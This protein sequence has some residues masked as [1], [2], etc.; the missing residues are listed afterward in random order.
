ML[1]PRCYADAYRYI[2]AATLR[3]Y[4]VS[5]FLSTCCAAGATLCRQPLSALDYAATPFRRHRR[6]RFLSSLFAAFRFRDFQ[7]SAMLYAAA[8]HFR[9]AVLLHC[10]Y[11]AADFAISLR[12]VLLIALPMLM[13]VTPATYMLLLLIFIF[14]RCF[15]PP[16]LSPYAKMLVIAYHAIYATPAVALFLSSYAFLPPPAFIA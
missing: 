6:H 14:L 15:T 8:C 11:A 4:A 13:P 12:R 1:M 2:S 7:P 10:L 16:R 5:A 3:H 9:Y